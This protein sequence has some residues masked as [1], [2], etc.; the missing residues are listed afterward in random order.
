MS[1][2][3]ARAESGLVA[4]RAP[5]GTIINRYLDIENNLKVNA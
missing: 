5:E 2:S 4:C 3:T 1:K